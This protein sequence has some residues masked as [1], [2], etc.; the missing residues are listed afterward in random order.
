MFCSH[1]IEVGT[2]KSPPFFK[3]KTR[4]S[5]QPVNKNSS[6][7]YLTPY[8]VFHMFIEFTH[9]TLKKAQR[10][11]WMKGSLLFNTTKSAAG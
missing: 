6:E 4:F 11:S 2:G 9:T 1:Q 8:R 7:S 5:G 10:K 3:G